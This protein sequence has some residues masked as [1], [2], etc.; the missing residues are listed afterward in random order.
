[1]GNRVAAA[2]VA[3][4]AGACSDLP[5]TLPTSPTEVSQPATMSVPPG[6]GRVV[7]TERWALELRVQ[8]VAGIECTDQTLHAARAV[9]LAVEVRDTGRLTLSLHHDTSPTSHAE[10]TGW[11]LEGGLEA[12][13]AVYD[14]LPCSGAAD[15]PDGAPSTLTGSFSADG[16]RFTAME[17]RR[18][19]GREEGEIVY[20]LAWT[21][22][23]VG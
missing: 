2:F 23:R 15:E 7:R 19:M 9:E 11:M 14:G 12:S 21:A 16:D 13:G 17:I 22:E 20:Y 1:M 8:D 3:C 4:L 18:Y 5:S 10:W 6:P